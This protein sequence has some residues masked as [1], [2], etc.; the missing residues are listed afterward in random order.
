[1][2]RKQQWKPIERYFDLDGI[3]DRVRNREAFA[4]FVHDFGWTEYMF[5][6][7]VMDFEKLLSGSK[8]YNKERRDAIGFARLPDTSFED[9]G[10]HS[11]AFRNNSAVMLC[12]VFLSLVDV[13]LDGWCASHNAEYVVCRKECAFHSNGSGILVLF[14][15]HDVAEYYATVLDEYRDPDY[16]K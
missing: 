12:S 6:P 14:M 9:M 5:H 2:K 13:D 11:R 16:V 4:K 10:G 8:D 1:M 7:I 15:T 3:A